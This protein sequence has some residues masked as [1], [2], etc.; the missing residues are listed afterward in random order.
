[1]VKIFIYFVTAL[2]LF[3]GN[4]QKD[5]LKCHI[6]ENIPSELIYRRYLAR[7]STQKNMEDAIFKYLKNPQKNRSILPTQFFR[8]FPLKGKTDLSDTDLKDDIKEYLEKFDV[9]RKLV[10]QE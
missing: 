8:K 10:L 6:K 9:K 4:L 5:C 3:G 7:Y 1:M 2:Y